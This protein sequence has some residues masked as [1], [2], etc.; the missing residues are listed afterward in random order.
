MEGTSL[1]ID[2]MAEIEICGLMTA[3]SSKKLKADEPY[4]CLVQNNQTHIHLEN[5]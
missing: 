5:I 3:L 4:W 2:E 1:G